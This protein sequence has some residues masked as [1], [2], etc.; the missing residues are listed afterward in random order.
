MP[1]GFVSV[2]FEWKSAW[3]REFGF[4]FVQKF[5]PRCADSQEI[6]VGRLDQSGGSA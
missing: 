2:H 4:L 5:A 1:C 6:L 3:F